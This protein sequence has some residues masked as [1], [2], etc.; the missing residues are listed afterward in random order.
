MTIE[1]H[2]SFS[3]KKQRASMHKHCHGNKK[4]TIKEMGLMGL[5]ESKTKAQ[6]GEKWMKQT[7]NKYI[8][9]N[10]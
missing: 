5:D 8:T 7:L 3:G 2:N 6:N 1:L 10:S 4:N 9:E